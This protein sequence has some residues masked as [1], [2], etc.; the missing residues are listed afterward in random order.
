MDARD[1]RL[2]GELALRGTGK[3]EAQQDEHQNASEL[4]AP[5]NRH[6]NRLNAEGRRNECSCALSLPSVSGPPP[7]AVGPREL[8]R[9]LAEAKEETRQVIERTRCHD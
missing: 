8:R 2:G 6:W 1:E 3:I 4:K 5:A 7:F 9:G